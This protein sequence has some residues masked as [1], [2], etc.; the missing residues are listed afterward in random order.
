MNAGM[1]AEIKCL[2]YIELDKAFSRFRFEAGRHGLYKEEIQRIENNMRS[3]NPFPQQKNG[4]INDEK[5]Y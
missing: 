2:D 4:G 3:I 5:R 1:N